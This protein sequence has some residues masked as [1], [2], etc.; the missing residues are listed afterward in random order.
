MNLK[1]DVEDTIHNWNES[2]EAL[3]DSLV[4]IN[5]FTVELISAIKDRQLD[6]E[7]SDFIER[8]EE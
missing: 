1:E 4:D 6:L 3:L 8:W 7:L 5:D 2:T